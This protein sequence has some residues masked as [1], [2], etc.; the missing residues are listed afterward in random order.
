MV[1]QPFNRPSARFDSEI[2]AR[3]RTAA[4]RTAAA[5]ITAASMGLSGCAST[6]PGDNDFGQDPQ[7]TGSKLAAALSP[8]AIGKSVSNTYKAG[9]EK[10]SKAIKPKPKA[11]E[12]AQSRTSSTAWWSRKNTD[13]E[14]TADFFVALAR[15]HEQTG[16]WDQAVMQYEKAIAID[17]HSAPALVGYAHLLD[18]RGQ[19]VKALDYYVRAVKSNPDD[20]SVVND[21]GLCYA[22][23]GKFDLALQY[24]GKA[25][26]LQPDRELYRNNIATV[27]VQIGH[28]RSRKRG[29]QAQVAAV[30]ASEPIAHYNVGVLLKQQGK[31]LEAVDQFAK[32]VEQDPGMDD[33]REWLDRLNAEEAPREELASVQVAESTEGNGISTPTA[34][35]QPV[36]DDGLEPAS[37]PSS[38]A[39][40]ASRP[41]TDG[42]QYS[43]PVT[44]DSDAAG[45]PPAPTPSRGQQP[46]PPMLR[47]GTEFRRY[48]RGRCRPALSSAMYRQA[49]IKTVRPAELL[50]PDPLCKRCQEFH[51]GCWEGLPFLAPVA[52]QHRLP[53]DRDRY[54]N[55]RAERTPH[56]L[57]VFARVGQIRVVGRR[58]A[59]NVGGERRFVGREAAIIA[60]QRIIEHGR[61]RDAEEP[62]L[63]VLDL[64][65]ADPVDLR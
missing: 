25:V 40:V 43:P 46:C 62:Q 12:G 6:K 63:A 53:V 45:T 14:P 2:V 11:P 57:H 64:A 59:L 44:S 56:H 51:R 58:A 10:V 1:Y 47:Q 24:L 17:S 49:G 8:A 4:L 3:R 15:V 50:G 5:L 34:H 28:S 20:A 26:E 13:P 21:L 33:A 48:V 54:V 38:R 30:Y 55:A 42:T 18:S 39:R 35:A 7:G 23:Q 16:E 52:D 29:R 19:K 65:D 22:R 37:R 61:L 36:T 9:S 60:P 31:R 41:K 27:L 32:A